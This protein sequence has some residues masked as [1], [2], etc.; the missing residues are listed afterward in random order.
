[1]QAAVWCGSR[2]VAA[3]VQG[4]GFSEGLARVSQELQCV[5]ELQIGT[6]ALELY[7]AD[8]YTADLPLLV[9]PLAFLGLPGINGR[10]LRAPLA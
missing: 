7:T 3:G 10:M 9:P 1:M 5:A 4:S 6:L 2:P 8:L